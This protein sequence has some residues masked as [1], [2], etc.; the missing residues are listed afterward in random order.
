[1]F[2]RSNVSLYNFLRIGIM[3]ASLHTLEMSAPE[4]PSVILTNWFQSMSSVKAI[5]RRFILNSSCL[6]FSVG[7]GM[8][9]GV[10][11]WCDGNSTNALLKAASDG[12][13]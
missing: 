1:M 10:V 2:F 12:F 3:A 7:N 4:Y 5:P 11:K 9:I 13:I 8:S 6:P